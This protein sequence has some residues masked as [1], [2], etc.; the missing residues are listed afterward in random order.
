MQDGEKSQS[1]LIKLSFH[2]DP[3]TFPIMFPSGDLGWSPLFKKFTN[4]DKNLSPLQFYLYRLAY[5]PNNKFD[6]ILFRRRLTQQYVI[7]AY[8]I[9]E[10]NRL[11][12]YRYNQKS[13]RHMHQNYQDAMAILRAIGRPDFFITLTCN[14]NWP[15]LNIILKKFQ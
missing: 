1:Y 14:S 4:T 8:I 15:K 13:P 3:M 5:L 10:S 2:V 9:I 11:I 7:Q 12:L 6:P